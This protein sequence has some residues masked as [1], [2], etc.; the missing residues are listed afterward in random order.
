MKKRKKSQMDKQ[1][2][3]VIEKNTRWTDQQAKYLKRNLYNNK[4]ES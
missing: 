2:K 1:T 4:P 3:E